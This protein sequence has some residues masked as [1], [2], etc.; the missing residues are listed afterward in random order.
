VRY[1]AR[2]ERTASHAIGRIRTVN[3]KRKKRQ[4]FPIELSVT[5]NRSGSGLHYALSFAISR[6]KRLQESWWRANGWRDWN[7]SSQIGHELANPLNGM[8]LTIQLLEQLSAA[9]QSAG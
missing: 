6:K 2:Y 7:H 5:E 4:L 3:A 1:I 9:D 8:F